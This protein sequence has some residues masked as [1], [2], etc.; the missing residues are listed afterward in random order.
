VQIASVQVPTNSGVLTIA[1]LYLPPGISWS[2]AEFDQLINL[3]DKFIAGGDFNAK[4]PWWGN[5]RT[6]SRGKQL[7]EA[8]ANSSCQVL[9]TGSPTFYSYNTRLIPTALDFFIVKGIAWNRLTVEGK[10]DLSSD[11]L[12][13]VATLFHAPQYKTRRQYLLP[14]GSSTEKFRAEL[15]RRIHLNTDINSTNDIEDAVRILLN[16]IKQAAAYA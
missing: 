4:H 2:R 3:G 13:I 5:T 6:C 9:A 16:N 12:P 7:Q 10:F 14:L 8:I 11:H 1:S 15:D